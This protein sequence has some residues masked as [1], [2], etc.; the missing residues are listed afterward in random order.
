MKRIIIILASVVG[1]IAVSVTIGGAAWS[2]TDSSS[3]TPTQQAQPIGPSVTSTAAATTAQGHWS[4]TTT[5]GGWGTTTTTEQGG[6]GTTTTTTGGWG[7]T[8][9]TTAPPPTTTTTAPPPTTTTTVTPQAPGA[10]VATSASPPAASPPASPAVTP[11]AAPTSLPFTGVNTKPLL[12]AGITLVALG[13]CLVAS[14]DSWRKARRRLRAASQW[15][16]LMMAF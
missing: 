6:W 13:L 14:S 1:L 16:Q 11:T 2:A 15:L 9:T 8:T 10:V 4:T 5:T 3:S 7:T 12:I